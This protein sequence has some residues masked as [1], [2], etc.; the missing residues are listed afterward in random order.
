MTALEVGHNGDF[1]F[2]WRVGS[3]GREVDIACAVPVATKGDGAHEVETLDASRQQAVRL[4]QVV[5]N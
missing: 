4:A 1:S 5:I 2:G 3:D